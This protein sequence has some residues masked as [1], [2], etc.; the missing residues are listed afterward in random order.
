MTEWQYM[1]WLLINETKQYIS[2]KSVRFCDKR[3]ANALDNM[4]VTER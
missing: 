1:V 4:S 3:T 2:E